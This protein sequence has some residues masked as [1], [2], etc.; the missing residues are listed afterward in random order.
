[1]A[2]IQNPRFNLFLNLH[3]CVIYGVIS[4]NNREAYVFDIPSVWFK[5]MFDS[6][7]EQELLTT[8][9]VN[10]FS[11]HLSRDSSIQHRQ[12]G[13]FWT[14]AVLCENCFASVKRDLRVIRYTVPK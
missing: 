6:G 1:M 9:R 5:V 8:N 10:A 14:N 11:Y 3:M 13:S 12:R 7:Y 4:P 2:D